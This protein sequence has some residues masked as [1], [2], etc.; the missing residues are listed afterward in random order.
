MERL[1]VD[2]HLLKQQNVLLF[3]RSMGLGGTENVVLMLCEIL[4]EKVNKIIVC[5]NGGINEKRL[6]EMGITH[7]T[8]PDIES[9]NPVVIFKTARILKRIIKNEKISIIHAHHRMAAFYI[10]FFRLFCGR[11]FFATSHNTF[12]NKKL[13]TRFSYKKCTLIA[14]GQKVK[15][16]LVDFFGIREERIHVIHN[17]VKPFLEKQELDPLVDH[18]RKQGFFIVGNIGRLSKQKGM[19]YFIES[20][21]KILSE[22]PKTAFFIVGSGEDE[23]KLKS[24]VDSLELNKNCIFTG[25]RSDCQNIASQFDLL[26]LSSLWEGLPLTPIEA[27]SVKKTIVATRVDGTPEVVH[28]L[29]NGI[30]VQ[31]CNPS[32]IAE[33]IIMLE[34]NPSLL[35]KLEFSAY[36]TYNNE[37]SFSVFSRR[38]IAFY[39]ERFSD[40]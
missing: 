24:L 35:K 19:E 40:E 26:V 28:H 4:K 15:D 16:N 11:V 18:F 27:F 37:F 36:E 10:S 5:S 14:C 8:I 31:P 12:Y 6:Q 25:Y 32:E 33:S 7:Y 22:K 34:N 13:L 38:I 39:K 30:L 23:N 29:N 21:P 9:K 1:I 3:T 20:M 17:A 2:L